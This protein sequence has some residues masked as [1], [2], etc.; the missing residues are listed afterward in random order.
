MTAA[1][2]RKL[3]AAPCYNTAQFTAGSTAPGSAQLR[4]PPRASHEP[5]KSDIDQLLINS[6]GPANVRTIEVPTKPRTWA[7]GIQ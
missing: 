2:S 3:R 5:S 6:G 4:C 7:P 1:A